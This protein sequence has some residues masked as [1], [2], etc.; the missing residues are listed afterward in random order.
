MFVKFYSAVALASLSAALSISECN[1]AI[2]F[3]ETVLGQTTTAS[4]VTDGILGNIGDQG[5]TGID[6]CVKIPSVWECNTSPYTCIYKD[7][8]HECVK[9]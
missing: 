2:D 3:T 5:V 8:A 7:T 4:S 1:K 9:L 6:P